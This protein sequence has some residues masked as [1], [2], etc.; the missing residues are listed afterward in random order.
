MHTRKRKT[1]ANDRQS[2]QNSI[3][4]NGHG[5]KKNNYVNFYNKRHCFLTTA[6]EYLN[7]RINRCNKMFS[8]LTCLSKLN[9]LLNNESD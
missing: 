5:D 7:E 4:V 8:A 9:Y 1:P 3:H 6:V 2:T